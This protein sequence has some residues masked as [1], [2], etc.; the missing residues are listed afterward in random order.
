MVLS[1]ARTYSKRTFNNRD[2]SQDVLLIGYGSFFQVVRSSFI[3]VWSARTSE[4]SS[5][6]QMIS[7]ISWVSSGSYPL[8]KPWVLVL[9]FGLLEYKF[10]LKIGLTSFPIFWGRIKGLIVIKV[11]WVSKEKKCTSVIFMLLY[12]ISRLMAFH[13]IFPHLKY[14]HSIERN[15]RWN[16]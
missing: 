5:R 1:V 13:N 3:L 10:I 2:S 8:D 9:N 15:Y 6:L 7:L 16:K 4:I 11:D 14:F 12:T